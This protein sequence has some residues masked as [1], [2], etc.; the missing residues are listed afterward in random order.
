[1]ANGKGDSD[2]RGSAAQSDPPVDPVVLDRALDET[3]E[4]IE[5]ATLARLGS[6]GISIGLSNEAK[7]RVRMRYRPQ[8]E[9]AMKKG[10]KWEE[11]R[12][13]VLLR[14]DQVGYAAAYGLLAVTIYFEIK[15]AGVGKRPGQ[16][17]EFEPLRIPS[18]NAALLEEAAKVIDCVKPSDPGQL[19]VVWDWCSRTGEVSFLS[20]IKAIV[21]SQSAVAEASDLEVIKHFAETSGDTND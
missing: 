6:A 10:R 12:G 9:S 17:I 14:A 21:S 16:E 8:F 18:V 3:V 19:R 20:F 4:R 13:S 7:D 5:R 15:R 1:M 11:D 2:N